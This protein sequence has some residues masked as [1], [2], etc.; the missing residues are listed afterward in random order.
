MKKVWTALSVIAVANLLA[1]TAFAGWL[2]QSDRLDMDRIRH[3]RV[4]LAKTITQQKAEED[5]AKAKLAEDEKQAEA[6]KQ[7][8]K[9][10]LTA[11]ER[12]S[13]RVEATELDIQR[14]ERL[15]REVQDMQR[16]LTSQRDKLD[17]DRAAF[18]E[19]KKA[20]QQSVADMTAAT[21][22]A[23]FQKT[24]GVIEALK[25]SQAVV[26]LKEM[27]TAG[28]PVDPTAPA[29]GGTA[30]VTDKPAPNKAMSQ[31]VCYLDAMDDKHRAK[32]MTE[33]AKT[34][35][36]LAADLLERIRKQGDFARVP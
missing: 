5:A 10:P 19:E 1:L 31:V 2:V 13:A 24:L 12:L 29:P 14:A 18:E 20:F 17:V 25:P 15:K 3:L 23:Q 35:S 16:Q 30:S 28:Q 21:T 6:A 32:I 9:P 7:A 4:E 26:M 36:K 11:A 22:D 27:L 34:D 8:A 33:L